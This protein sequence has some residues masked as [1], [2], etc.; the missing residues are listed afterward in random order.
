M[1]GAPPYK[2]VRLTPILLLAGSVAL[3][4]VVATS[5]YRSLQE[6]GTETAHR[7]R[8]FQV[9]LHA[10]RLLTVLK[11]VETGQRGFA[12]TGDA[13]YLQPFTA[14][15]AAI[16]PVLEQLATELAFLPGYRSDFRDFGDLDELVRRRIMF[17]QRNVNA[18]RHGVLAAELQRVMF[19]EG[20]IA[21][22]RVRTRID[23]LEQRLGAEIEY[24]NERVATVMRQSL[25]LAILLTL[26]GIM[27]IVA[28][29]ALLQLEQRRRLY[30][31]WALREANA[32]LEDT[33]TQRT[34][35]LQR[36]LAELETFAQHLDRT[37]ED[38]RRRLA[39]EVHD[40]LGQIFTALKMSINRN[41][42]GVPGIAEHLEGINA[43]LAN[44]IATARRIASELRP[45]ILD[46]LGLGVAL[47]R[48]A[49]QFAQQ[50]GILGETRVRD[51]E[52]L[53]I[54]QATQL[55]R[56]SQEALTNVARHAGA[57]RV[58]IEGEAAAEGYRLAIEDDGAGLDEH[59]SPALGMLSMRERASLSGGTLV[60]GP[61]RAGGLRVQV[62]LPLGRKEALQACAS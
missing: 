57:R 33:V 25:W 9:L 44:G 26:T 40:Q 7:A 45:S 53:S 62:T 51:C 1:A 41:L 58:W 43:M 39:R 14:G 4:L 38:E 61:G 30:A 36:A 2:P 24:R 17:A 27:L 54:E 11:D 56:I 29:W 55:Y 18:L 10:N 21:M 50:T 15:L 23:A 31:E 13:E 46:D 49:Q 42:R 20:R 19:D 47:E 60:L 16:G 37:V 8:A 32:R 59:S 34:A 5:G 12:L 48:A 22:S 35:E 52:R 3:F 6:L 28:A